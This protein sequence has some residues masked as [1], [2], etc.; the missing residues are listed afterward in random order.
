MAVNEFFLFIDRKPAEEIP[1]YLANSDV[2]LISL[3]K[4][5]VFSITI[6]AKTQSCMACGTP[7]LVSA[8]GEV[9]K[10]VKEAKAGLVSNAED[11][12]GLYTNILALSKMP[13]DE[14]LKF[15]TNALEY[16][17]KHFEKRKL[18]GRIDQIFNE[19]E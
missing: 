17:K 8:D 9:Q 7:L 12:E 1:R 15:G 5:K 14:L 4:S 6:P 11:A 10:I 19:G 13:K 3:S 16:S 2:A 18:L